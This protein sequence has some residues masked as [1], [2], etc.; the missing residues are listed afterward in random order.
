MEFNLKNYKLV[1]VDA[2]YP[3]G[4]IDNFIGN[5]EYENYLKKSVPLIV[6]TI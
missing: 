5:S 6:M 3:I 2:P 4:Y 1:N